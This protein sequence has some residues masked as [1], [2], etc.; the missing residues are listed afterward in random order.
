MIK[1]ERK[2][3]DLDIENKE[4]EQIM[5]TQYSS[6]NKFPPKMKICRDHEKAQKIGVDD[7]DDIR[8]C[9]CCGYQV[10]QKPYNLNCHINS[11]S[12]YGV[13]LCQFFYFIRFS[14]AITVLICVVYIYSL[15]K[16]M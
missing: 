10:S 2:I 8:V 13:G 16:N 12:D 15:Y 7:P 4:I 1:N 5:I 14:I 3:K 6:E 9:Q 11:L